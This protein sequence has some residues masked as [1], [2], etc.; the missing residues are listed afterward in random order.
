M[1]GVRDDEGGY[2]LWGPRC[3]GSG[4][5]KDPYQSGVG[6]Y[7]SREEEVAFPSMSSRRKCRFRSR[8]C[9]SEHW[10]TLSFTLFQ[11]AETPGWAGSVICQ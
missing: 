4:S 3:Q 7:P 5:V 10:A 2:T 11:I 6:N 1:A 9:G 8:R